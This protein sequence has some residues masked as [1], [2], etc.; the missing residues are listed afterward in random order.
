MR[1]LMDTISVEQLT[2]KRRDGFRLGPMNLR[3]AAGE[4]VALIG[5]SGCGKTTFLRLLAGLEKPASGTIRFGEQIVSDARRLLPP[6]ERGI[7]FVFQDGALWP[8]LTARKQL[9]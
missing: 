7:G 1:E 5:P 9:E 6:G 2:L 8:H 3:L 4:R